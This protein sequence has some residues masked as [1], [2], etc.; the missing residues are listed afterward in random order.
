M[1]HQ[2]YFLTSNA[3]KAQDFTH[4]GLGVKEFHEEIAEVLS[5]DV[6]EV[7]LY[8]ARATGLNNI[9]VEDTSLQVEGAAFFGTEIK[10]VYDEIKDDAQFNGHHAQ[11]KVSICMRLDE[12]FY[13]STGILNGILK[14]PAL[15]FGYHFDRIF[16]VKK[17]NDYV[18]FELLS[19][20]EKVQV[21]PRFQAL[22]KLTDAL[23]SGDYSKLL[24]I[25]VKEVKD[26]DGDYQI[27][28]T[29][30][31]KLKLA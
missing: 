27:E 25:P 6:E 15:D 30:F 13:I 10:H 26:W 20:E 29:P 17:D 8:K 21:G 9:L 14:Y 24:R 7:A 2:V 11:W 23:N 4:F 28:K 12:N 16:A 22:K 5:A 3:K 1:K 18:Q 31:K 19:Q